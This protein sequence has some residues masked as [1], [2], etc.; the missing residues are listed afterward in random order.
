MPSKV[1]ISDAYQPVIVGAAYLVKGLLHRLRVKEIIDQVLPYQPDIPTTYGALAQI[2]IANRMTFQPAPLYKLGP[3]AAQHGLD[4]VFGVPA[5]ALD[6]DRLGALMDHL[7]THQ[8]PIWRGILKA[9]QRRFKLDWEWLHEDTT[10]VYFEGDYTDAQGAPLPGG[11]RIP[12]LLEGYN[13]DGQRDKVQLVLSLITSG[14]VPVY[15]RPWDGNQTDDGV[16]LA[17]MTELRRWLLAPDNAVIVG[18]RKLCNQ[19]TM[20]S[21]CREGQR[22]LGAHPWTETAQA[23][24]RD[25]QP[26]LQQRP[27]A[28]MPVPYV[29]R[30]DARKPEAAR[31][32]YR[33]YEVPH[34]LSDDATGQTYTVR[35]VFSWSSEKAARDAQQR[36]KA[37]QAGE[38]ALRRLAGLLGKYRY[39]RRA[40]IEAQ[41][42]QSLE[43][44]HAAPYL[45]CTLRGTDQDQAWHLT[46]DVDQ[47]QVAADALRDGV[48][49][50]CT[51]VPA[52]QLTAPDA[53][54]KY[55][56]QVQTEQVIDFIKSPVQI[57]P[58]WLHQP[59][60]IAGLTLLIMIAVLVASLLEQQVRRWIAKTGKRLTGLRPEKRDDAYPTAKA[61]LEVFATYAVV[62]VRGLRGREKLWHLST[63]D[64]LQKKIW[65]I[66]G[67]PALQTLAEG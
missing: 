66:L 44:V 26:P 10:S 33:V 28:W 64:P 8:V 63:L 45:I 59:K 47:G 54:I 20:L 5:E 6:D 14:R 4:R 24:W 2:V 55:K 34:T 16:Y 42:A 40:V 18:D 17:D 46:W 53:M 36:A 27:A 62:I 30:Q 12:R 7:G 61:L 58:M 43:K 19:A 3:W 11:E 50:L 67:L 56:E 49:L 41:I 35:W 13:K 57:R 52:T 38:A 65:D 23:V 51:N 1:T 22:F 29:S 9:A 60:R 21:F 39:K 37:I 15:Y 31:P 32:T 48:A 25:I